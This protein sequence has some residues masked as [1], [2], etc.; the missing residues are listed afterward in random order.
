MN[1]LEFFTKNNKSGSK[2]KE[3][4]LVMAHPEVHSLVVAYSSGH[5]DLSFMERVFLFVNDMQSPPSCKTCGGKPNFFGT[6]K[7]GY[8][9]YCSVKC[10][11]Q[12]DERKRAIESSF[13]K[14]HGVTN[15]NQL[16]TV[17]SK[18]V[19][20]YLQKYGVRNPMHSNVIK[21]KLKTTLL[22][23]YGVDNPMKISHVIDNFKQRTSV[24]EEFNVKRMLSRI[25][26]NQYKFITH[27]ANTSTFVH[28]KCSKD[29]SINSNLLNSRLGIVELCLNCNPLK[30][31]SDIEKRIVEFLNEN[32]IS[33]ELK[34]R[35]LLGGKEIDI[36]IPSHKLGIEINGLYWHSDKFSVMDSEY[37][38]NK[39]NG[40][41]EN[42]IQLLHFYEDEIRYKIEIVKSMILSKIGTGTLHRIAARKCEVK[43]IARDEYRD[44]TEN[45]HLQGYAPA[46]IML[47]LFSENE[48]V[49]VMGFNEP[50]KIFSNASGYDAELVRYCSK[51][52]LSVIGG[53]SKLFSFFLKN[54][55]YRRILSYS[56]LRYSV[57]NVYISLGF[58]HIGV[59]KPGYFYFKPSVGIRETR[60]KYQKHK[61]I[62]RGYDPT[63]SE[64]EI[65]REEGYYRIYDCG[66]NK[67]IY[68]RK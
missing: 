4:Y 26:D 27:S 32:A 25:D 58:T 17:K 33:Y 50:R 63:K 46:S 66:Q 56:D 53:A 40:C 42:D 52:G 44:F 38:I 57:G 3:K 8:G 22:D 5:T 20:T 39:T 59:S 23:K 65:M 10:M 37:H 7:K 61:L 60:F 55:S 54:Y 49:S 14:N 68:E 31:Y 35:R 45:F 18:K 1:Y 16:D 15:H 24:G 30:S 36:L 62:T 21:S 34:N 6:L 2:T 28:I 12:N 13:Q 51:I 43:L 19:S 29:F 11:N 67:F 47:G 48:C 41:F 9:S 64:H